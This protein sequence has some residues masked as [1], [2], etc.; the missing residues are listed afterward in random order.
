MFADR[1][2]QQ[3]ITMP[4]D[5][6]NL[7]GTREHAMLEGDASVDTMSW[8]IVQLEPSMH[9]VFNTRPIPALLG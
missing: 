3:L 2:I 9:V 8:Y 5:A 7:E 6:P 1:C 4:A